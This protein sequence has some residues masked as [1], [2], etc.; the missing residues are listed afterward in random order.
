MYSLSIIGVFIILGLAFLMRAKWF[1]SCSKSLWIQW[2]RLHFAV[3]TFS[4]VFIIYM[5]VFAAVKPPA[6]PTA[7]PLGLEST[8]V[9]IES[10]ISGSTVTAP[11]TT[12]KD[13][14]SILADN[15]YERLAETGDSFISRTVT[16]TALPWLVMPSN[17]IVYSGWTN[18]GVAEDTFWVCKTNPSASWDFLFADKIVDGAHVSSSGTISFD[19]PK[20]SPTPHEM[21]D[22][23]GI[24]FLAPFH[25]TLSMIPPNGRFWH[26]ATESNSVRFTWQNFLVGRDTNNAISFQAELF[27]N[28]DYTF[29]YAL[30]L[31]FLSF[32][33][34]FV[35]GAQFGGVGETFAMN[36]YSNL[37]DGLDIIWDLPDSQVDTD[38][39]GTY[40]I[41][42][43]YYG[44]DSKAY[45]PEDWDNDGLSNNFEY[46]YTNSVPTNGIERLNAKLFD[47]DGDKLPD[48][49]EVMYT[50]FNPLVAHSTSNE[51]LDKDID[52]DGLD[53]AGE[54][55]YGTSPIIADTD[56]DG[57]NDGAER[58]NGSDPNQSSEGFDTCK[59]LLCLSA[60]DSYDY[61]MMTVSDRR[62]NIIVS[63]YAYNS[64]LFHEVGNIVDFK[65]ARNVESTEYLEQ[66]DTLYYDIDVLTE[67][68]GYC[69]STN[70]VSSENI[71]EPEVLKNKIE[72]SEISKTGLSA[73]VCITNGFF[74]F[75]PETD[76][77]IDVSNEALGYVS[78]C[79]LYPSVTPFA[80]FTAGIGDVEIPP[81]CT[82]P[83]VNASS[84]YYDI[85]QYMY[86]YGT[87]SDYGISLEF[88]SDENNEVSL[89]VT[90]AFSLSSI[91]VNST[92]ANTDVYINLADFYDNSYNNSFTLPSLDIS[93]HTRAVDIEL[94]TV[95]NM[96]EQYQHSFCIDLS[97]THCFIYDEYVDLTF[98]D[99]SGLS[100]SPEVTLPYTFNTKGM[101]LGNTDLYYGIEAGSRCSTSLDDVGITASFAVPEEGEDGYVSASDFTTVIALAIY[102]D[103]IDVFT[104]NE[105]ADS[106]GIININD[107]D[108]ADDFMPLLVETHS[109]ATCAYFKF[110]YDEEKLKLWVKDGTMGRTDTYLENGGDVLKDLHAYSYNDIFS[111]G[112]ETNIYVQALEPGIHDIN[113]TYVLDGHD[114]CTESINFVSLKVDINGDYDRDDE[115]EDSLHEADEVCFTNTTGYVILAN[116]DDDDSSGLPDATEDSIINNSFDTNEVY[117]IEISKFNIPVEKIP[118]ALR[119]EFRLVDPDTQQP[120]DHFNLFSNIT[121][122][123]SHSSNNLIID[124]A[125]IKEQFVG[126]G[127]VSLG[128]EAFDYGKEVKI[129]MIVW[130]NSLKIGTDEI[131]VLCAPYFISPNDLSADS[132]F[133]SFVTHE[134]FD[135]FTNGL[136]GV[137]DV[138]KSID[139]PIN[140]GSQ[141]ETYIQDHV[142]FGYTRTGIGQETFRTMEVVLG[143]SN[144]TPDLTDLIGTNVA[145]Y[146]PYSEDDFG[147]LMVTPQTSNF[148]YG[149]TVV[150]STCL[151]NE[152]LEEQ[153]VQTTGGEVINI[154]TSWLT[155]PHVDNLV[156]FIPVGSSFKV[157]VADL[158]LAINILNTYTNESIEVFDNPY[159][160]IRNR[161]ND[162]ANSTN[163]YA[164]TTKLTN[165]YEVLEEQLGIDKTTFIHVPVAFNPEDNPD[166]G[167]VKA[168][169]PVLINMQ[170]IKSQNQKR[171]F[172]PK[173]FFEP[174][175]TNSVNG[176][177][178]KLNLIGFSDNEIRIVPTGEGNLY[179]PFSGGTLGGDVHCISNPRLVPPDDNE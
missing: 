60:N 172:V 113:V 100:L 25:S 137:C 154:D 104:G 41:V 159:N 127:T 123:A 128:L 16:N 67:L 21:P 38:G 29:R 112:A 109:S 65:F 36:N 58:A 179:S 68:M 9:L 20:G 151:Y 102:M 175:Y 115:C 149:I 71:Y 7:P 125:T 101:S 138:E 86:V 28:G 87:W 90:N 78:P 13:F 83:K 63:A 47:S 121:V 152:F 55:V 176:L 160:P 145:F 2:K 44:F 76:I 96:K 93:H 95:I 37:A 24:D 92:T 168:L 39:D 119:I 5:T 1:R 56:G 98:V 64:F 147:D 153:L 8:P 43:L 10:Q 74:C 161:Y 106:D 50:N 88:E 126:N 144:N 122:S 42:E 178:T 3:K 62:T 17:A 165:M 110:D 129:E 26:Y 136:S 51:Y 120:S 139:Y 80:V 150:G 130:Y 164:I 15:G 59:T 158:D 27:I 124:N 82:A 73:S 131:R 69:Y 22:G 75:E 148:P 99:N 49:F 103:E 111:L 146:A 107:L 118:D 141:N 133:V 14:P 89:P 77:T 97:G 4:L 91:D 35:I 116:M 61:M 132:T 57:V 166:T 6:A 155:V 31:H 140:I 54:M 12:S 40:D 34:D 174:F 117:K 52:G 135:V 134:C 19:I 177:K 105:D 143:K 156:H 142:E 66:F 79:G 23:T 162:P 167:Y 108:N 84:I 33:N 46:Y 70:Y 169:L 45:T 173:S 85:Y 94:P 32:T 53:N 18:Y 11:T 114:L 170:Y 30:P 163:I 81:Y 72:S 171:L 157:M 48:I